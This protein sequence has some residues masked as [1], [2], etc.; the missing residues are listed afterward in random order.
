MEPS[1]SDEAKNCEPK[2]AARLLNRGCLVQNLYGSL[3][4]NISAGLVGGPGNPKRL[5]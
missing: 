4:A 3:I 5:A 1:L 2:Q